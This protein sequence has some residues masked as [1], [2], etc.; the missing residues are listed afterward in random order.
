MN[1]TVRRR[2][3]HLHYCMNTFRRA[4]AWIG[5][6]PIEGELEFLKTLN[7]IESQAMRKRH[8]E[9]RPMDDHVL[10]A[11]S[12]FWWIAGLGLFSYLATAA[13]YWRK[14]NAIRAEEAR[15]YGRSTFG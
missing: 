12:A 14:H 15:R 13:R 6:E 1:S 7:D 9:R 8:L 10:L 5:H 2:N 3:D 11:T 4:V